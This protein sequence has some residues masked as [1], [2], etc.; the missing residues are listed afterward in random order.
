MGTW[1]TPNTLVSLYSGCEWFICNTKRPQLVLLSF[2]LDFLVR[3][4]PETELNLKVNFVVLTDALKYIPRNSKALKFPLNLNSC[5]SRVL[6]FLLQW[7]NHCYANAL[8]SFVCLEKECFS[9][10]TNQ[11]S[12]LQ[13]VYA[14]EKVFLKWRGWRTFGPHYTMHRVANMDK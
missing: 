9:K 1:N 6:G 8:I 10:L 13:C 4:L 7:R 11:M 2:Q 3:T 5:W 14:F 12:S